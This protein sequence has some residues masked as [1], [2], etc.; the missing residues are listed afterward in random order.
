M[1]LLASSMLFSQDKYDEDKY[2]DIFVKE[3]KS[4]TF[5]QNIAEPLM[6]GG[7]VLM[8]LTFPNDASEWSEFRIFGQLIAGAAPGLYLL[9]K[10]E[11]R[12]KQLKA[13]NKTVDIETLV[14]IEALEAALNEDRRCGKKCARNKVG[15]IL[16]IAGQ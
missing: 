15:I 1:I 6:Y 4:A 3:Y 8:F 16:A 10:P 11:A 9:F 14:R 13:S 12:L 5:K 2:V 7:M